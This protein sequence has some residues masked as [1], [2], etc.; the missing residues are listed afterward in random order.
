MVRNGTG[1]GDKK[2][3]EKETARE[4]NWSYVILV[5]PSGEYQLNMVLRIFFIVYRSPIVKIHSQMYKVDSFGGSFQ[6][7]AV[8]IIIF[9]KY[10]TLVI[11]EINGMVSHEK[12]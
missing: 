11:N 3:R 10:Y 5:N 2:E 7:N 9:N 1:S 4:I 8:R 12:T 6:K